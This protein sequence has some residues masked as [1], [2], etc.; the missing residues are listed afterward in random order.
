V[1]RLN[2]RAAKR[3]QARLDELDDIERDR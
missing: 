2:V 3:L 1:W